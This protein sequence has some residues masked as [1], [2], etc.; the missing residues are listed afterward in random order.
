MAKMQRDKGARLE[1]ELVALHKDH[2]IHAERV[3]LSGATHYQGSG[4]DIDVYPFFDEQA[5][6]CGEVKGR[7]NGFRSLYGWLDDNDFLAVRA[8][9]KEWLV[10]IPM[11]IWFSLIGR[12]R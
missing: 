7:A 1:R 4:H 2:G 6:L 10:V 5:P 9:R 8:N 12:P 11:R 3:P